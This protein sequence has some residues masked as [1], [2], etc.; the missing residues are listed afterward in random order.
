VY[1]ATGQKAKPKVHVSTESIATGSIVTESI[2]TCNELSLQ[3]IQAKHQKHAEE[4][5]RSTS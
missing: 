1:T 5:Q 2:V 3:E 4:K